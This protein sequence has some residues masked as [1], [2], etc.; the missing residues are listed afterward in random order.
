[1][2]RREEDAFVLVCDSCKVE[3]LPFDAAG[4]RPAW[5]QTVG[6]ATHVCPECAIRGAR[7]ARLGED[8]Q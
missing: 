1:V 7:A 3:T 8:W 6:S 2:I 4:E 5:W